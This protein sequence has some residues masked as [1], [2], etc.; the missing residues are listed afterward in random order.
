MTFQ[1]AKFEA[2]VKYH[3][4]INDELESL[5]PPLHYYQFMSAPIKE[6]TLSNIGPLKL[7]QY[8]NEVLWEHF[9]K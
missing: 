8:L 5:R 7:T 1:S 3:E 2:M 4:S 9:D 6:L